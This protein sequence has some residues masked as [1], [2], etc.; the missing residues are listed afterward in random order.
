VN[1]RELS[2]LLN[3]LVLDGQGEE[4]VLVMLYGR[5]IDNYV[6]D[7]L[8]RH[9]WTVTDVVPDGDHGSWWVGLSV[10]PLD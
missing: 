6:E 7:R 5:P 2:N 8:G 1:V 9:N 10:H 4:D 3:A